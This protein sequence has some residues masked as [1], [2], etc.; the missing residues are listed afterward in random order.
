MKN[1]HTH[2]RGVSVP[3][4]VLVAL[5]LIALSEFSR[6]LAQGTAFPPD[7]M[8]YQ[9]FLVDGNGNALGDPDPKNY[10]VVFSIY[11]D[12]SASADANLLWREQQTVPVDQG[13]FSVILGEGADGDPVRRPALSTVFASANASIRWVGIT[14]KGIGAGGSNVDILPRLRLLSSPYAF[15]ASNAVKLVQDNGTPLITGTGGGNLTM[16]GNLTLNGTLAPPLFLG[17]NVG[18]IISVHG[19][20]GGNHYG[21]GIQPGLMQIHSDGAGSAVAFGYGRSGAFTERMRIQG[22]GDVLIGTTAR[23]SKLTVHAAGRGI[24]HTDGTRE[25]GT[26]VNDKGGWIG[27]ITG[28]PLQ[29]YTAN[30]QPKMTLTAGASARLGI[31]TESPVSGLD[32]A[33][34]GSLWRSLTVRGSGGSDVVVIGNLSGTPTIGGHDAALSRWTSLSLGSGNVGIGISSPQ[35]SLHVNGSVGIHGANT[36][37]FGVGLNK[38]VDEGKIG[39]GAFTPGALD[40]VGAGTSSGVRKI[41]FHSQGGSTFHGRVGIGTSSPIAPLHV[42]GASFNN[43]RLEAYLDAGGAHDP[44]GAGVTTRGDLPHSIVASHRIRVAAVDIPSDSRIKNAIGITEGDH[45]LQAI[46]QLA[47]KDY[48]YV[49]RVSND[50]RPQ[51]GLIAQEVEDVMPDAV[52]STV[53]FIPNIYAPARTSH[54]DAAGKSLTIEL[55]H[56]H[57]LT[58]EDVVCLMTTSGRTEA[59]VASVPSPTS[60]TIRSDS[61]S[62]QVFVIG[63]QVS[64]FRIVDYDRIFTTGIGAI[65]ELAKQVDTLKESQARITKL[66]VEAGKVPVLEREIEELR[67]QVSNQ[68]QANRDWEARVATLEKLV[69]ATRNVAVVSGKAVDAG[70]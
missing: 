46:R 59:R 39:Y 57:G 66:E 49:D 65:Q 8:T 17:N 7:R 48:H 23:V 27:T 4:A 16:N 45:A 31:G 26:Y 25:M 24:A 35:R 19:A 60:F 18:D 34:D 12:E 1:S 29:F 32:V 58:P 13:Y 40:I 55:E 44:Q 43:F 28:H 47:V 33:S 68:E 37:E 62:D 22:N 41:V 70:R 36:L 21:F 30:S 10:D 2:A 42:E 53:G 67:R 54:Y 50:P 69:G 5:T 11:N 20:P 63:K 51:R 61:P 3:S 9:G 64:D 14:V 38:G 15:L 56:S 52:I 6:A